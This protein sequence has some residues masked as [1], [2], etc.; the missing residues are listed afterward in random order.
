MIGMGIRPSL[1]AQI[2]DDVRS[3]SKCASLDVRLRSH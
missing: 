2:N 3:L 1:L